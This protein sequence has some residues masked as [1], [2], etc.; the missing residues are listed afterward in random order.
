M[1]ASLKLT[2]W[3]YVDE[4][5][6]FSVDNN[7]DAHMGEPLSKGARVRKLIWHCDDGYTKAWEQYLAA[8]AA[9]EVLG[10]GIGLVA[11]IEDEWI[12]CHHTNL[13]E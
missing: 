6:V 13:S 12:V 7:P 11:K 1:P 10:G 2:T 8:Q 3:R 5:G 9:A 4:L